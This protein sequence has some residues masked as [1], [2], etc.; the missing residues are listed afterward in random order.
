[1]SRM[2]VTNVRVDPYG[3]RKMLIWEADGHR[4]HTWIDSHGA[5]APFCYKRPI[6]GSMD[7]QRRLNLNSKRSLRM[8][9]TAR[10]IA[11]GRD[12]FAGVA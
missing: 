12:L 1:M 11:D 8:Y 6:D 9:E 5:P 3:F 10:A 4:F 2:A 7:S